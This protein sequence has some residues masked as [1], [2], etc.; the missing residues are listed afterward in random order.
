MHLMSQRRDDRNQVRPDPVER[1][2]PPANWQRAGGTGPVYARL[3]FLVADSMPC[4]PDAEAL[5]KQ[6]TDVI[7]AGVDHLYF[8]QI[9]VDQAAFLKAWD[10]QVGPSLRDSPAARV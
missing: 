5:I 2:A 10:D 4:G 1:G 8:R 7:A 3:T 9:D 6:A